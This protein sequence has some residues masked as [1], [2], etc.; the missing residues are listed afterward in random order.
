MDLKTFSALSVPVDIRN[1]LPPEV[2]AYVPHKGPCVDTE[3]HDYNHRACVYTDAKEDLIPAAATAAFYGY[4]DLLENLTGQPVPGDVL[5]DILEY[6]IF[7]E[8]IESVKFLISRG[9]H[10]TMNC[11]DAS[12]RST[13]EI[14]RLCIPL[15]LRDN[16]FMARYII[17]IVARVGDIEALEYLCT[18]SD[19]R[20]DSPVDYAV[21]SGHV[22]FAMRAVDLGFDIGDAAERAAALGMERC[23][24][25]FFG[26]GCERTASILNAA[27]KSSSLRC[28]QIALDVGCP[29]S[30]L[31]LGCAVDSFS[32]ESVSFALDNGC[33]FEDPTFMLSSSWKK[34]N[35]RCLEILVSRYPGGIQAAVDYLL[36]EFS[37]EAIRAFASTLES[38]PN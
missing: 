1:L 8:R 28:A 29:F 34:R 22:D 14:F 13:R 17:C 37:G 6:A 4:V 30:D 35:V 21:L 9:A 23:L 32:P 2:R 24:G 27:L 18:L 26:R 36:E 19:Y 25:L 3:N 12:L 20:G 15:Y 10:V 11:V 31:S 7:G 5:S 33:P 16:E 38:I